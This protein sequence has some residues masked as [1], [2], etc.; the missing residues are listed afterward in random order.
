VTLGPLDREQ[1]AEL[2]GHLLEGFRPPA[3][4]TEKLFGITKGNPLFVEGALRHLIDTRTI[5]RVEDGWRVDRDIPAA[6]PL[7]L[8]ELIRGRLKIIDAEAAEL[9]REAA[10]VG[11]NFEFEVVRA[12]AGKP[13]GEA[14]D[15]VAGAVKT[16][17]VRETGDARGADYEFAAGAV[18][19]A[20]Y[21]SLD[22]D[23]QKDAHRRVAESSPSA[24][25]RGPRTRP[26]SPGTSGAPATRR[27]ATASPRPVRERASSS[28]T[29]TPS[30]A[31]AT[32]AAR[33][34]R[35]HDPARR[36]WPRP[37]RGSARALVAAVRELARAPESRVRRRHAL[38]R[39]AGDRAGARGLARL[40][41]S[42]RGNA[43][44][45]DGRPVADKAL[46]EG[47][48]QE[49]LVEL[50]RAN[51]IKSLTFLK[52]VAPARAPRRAPRDGRAQLAGGGRRPAALV[53]E[54]V[55]GD[56]DLRTVGVVQK[57]SAL[58]RHGLDAQQGPEVKGRLAEAHA[59]LV[60]DLLGRLAAALVAA[61][62]P[63][64]PVEP[65]PESTAELDRALRA[66]F[67]HAPALA[68]HEGDDDAIVLNGTTLETKPLGP[69][70]PELL[71]LLRATRACAA[72]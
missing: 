35:G 71:R 55:R 45:L 61:R 5:V 4:F 58:Q 36:P 66:V 70:G 72:S 43:L 50:Y 23:E 17:L 52:P 24:A 28:S 46:A 56:R 62:A 33:A 30:R 21:A 18:H 1:T 32:G 59:P 10:V 9:L 68:L 13:E 26:R 39:L 40:T 27:S 15:A 37:S 11:P 53:L 14:L 41:I 29:A 7:G 8:D 16:K 20:T 60:L 31:S 64:A 57:A 47:P 69:S 22:P 12:S 42:H 67:Q 49:G 51:G 2:A 38:G 54:R 6:L 48:H 34:S 65:G 63:G 19:E 3:T 25:R 44:T